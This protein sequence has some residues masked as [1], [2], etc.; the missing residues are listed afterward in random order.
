MPPIYS[1]STR[2]PGSHHGSRLANRTRR[3]HLD[4]EA[5]RVIAHVRGEPGKRE[6]GSIPD[7][8]GTTERDEGNLFPR[9]KR[10]SH[11]PRNTPTTQTRTHQMAD[12]GSTTRKC[13]SAYLRATALI[14]HS[15]PQGRLQG[16]L[17]TGN[18]PRGP[19][20]PAPP[21]P[22]P[23]APE[24][25]QRTRTSTSAALKVDSRCASG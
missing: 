17:R 4:E 21:A 18:A 13:A 22:P 25:P 11:V 7:L 8:K 9:S 20:T 16:G 2:G 14:C 1:I 3:G 24:S 23:G 12:K 15:V 5:L 10:Y 19:S 6:H